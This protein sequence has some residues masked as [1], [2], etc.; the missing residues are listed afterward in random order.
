MK[1]K[2][3]VR[4][5]QIGTQKRSISVFLACKMGMK[6]LAPCT[7][8]DRWTRRWPYGTSR[9]SRAQK[10]QEV[11]LFPAGGFPA[12]LGS[13]GWG[14]VLSHGRAFGSLRDPAGDAE[15]GARLNLRAAHRTQRPL[16]GDESQ[17][18]P[19]GAPTLAPRRLSLDPVPSPDL[20][21]RSPDPGCGQNSVSS[22]QNRS[23]NLLRPQGAWKRVRTIP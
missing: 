15:P 8:S 2:K 6:I 3:P 12:V 19:E 7:C 11:H 20:G 13:G 5:T 17:P 1:G 22:Y 16:E 18:D 21:H 10:D 9:V 14:H 23:P 4:D